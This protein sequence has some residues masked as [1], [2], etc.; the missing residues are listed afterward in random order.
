MSKNT[1]DDFLIFENDDGELMLSLPAKEEE[2][3]SPK[4]LVA[5]NGNAFLYRTP[6]DAVF[7]EGIHPDILQKFLQLNEIMVGEI[8]KNEKFKYNYLAKIIKK[9]ILPNNREQ[10]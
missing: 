10:K 9:D 1:Q 3:V 4:I 2:P 5:E 6:N 7:L 8:D